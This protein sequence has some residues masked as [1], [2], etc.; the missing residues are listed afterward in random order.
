MLQD[1]AEDHAQ[2]LGFGL[3]H[4]TKNNKAWVAARYHIKILRYPRQKQNITLKTWPSGQK[5]LLYYRDFE[6]LD[7]NGDTLVLATSGW[8]VIDLKSRR[9][10]RPRT[11]LDN[12]PTVDKRAIDTDFEPLPEPQKCEHSKEFATRFSDID[13]NR[14][15]NSTVY[16]T[17]A[18]E[19][20]PRDFLW[21]HL[22][23]EIKIAFKSETLFGDTVIA[24]ADILNGN[25]NPRALH[26]ITDS[27]TS[28]EAARLTTTWTP[29]NNTDNKDNF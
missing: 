26:L 5:G 28:E 13:V 16:L 3:R 27:R 17:W 10:L 7:E 1:I 4:L 8:L 6:M 19:T 12:F 15:I 9:P 18:I 22:P 23:S 11:A 25:K 24:K 29:I 2:K 20:M 21:N 14:H